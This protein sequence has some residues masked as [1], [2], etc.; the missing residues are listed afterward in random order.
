MG[1]IVAV[2]A[3]ILVVGICV[4]CIRR[5]KM[6]RTSLLAD[7]SQTEAE[8]FGSVSSCS[9]SNIY[10]FFLKIKNFYDS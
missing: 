4:Y 10:F 5:K 9:L 3:A 6:K 8:V 2:V 1:G 7:K